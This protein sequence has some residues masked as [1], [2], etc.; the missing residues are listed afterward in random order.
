MTRTMTPTDEDDRYEADDLATEDHE[1]DLARRHGITK[2]CPCSGNC[3]EALCVDGF[4]FTPEHDCTSPQGGVCEGC[5][6]TECARCG[7]K[8]CCDL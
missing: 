4:T 5:Y 1:R 3:C 7:A 2:G 8:C 6:V